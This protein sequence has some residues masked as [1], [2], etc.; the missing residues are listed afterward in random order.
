MR[1]GSP[2][3]HGRQSEIMEVI[4]MAALAVYAN[5]IADATGMASDEMFAQF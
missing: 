2:E 4:A 3:P 1:A 5:T